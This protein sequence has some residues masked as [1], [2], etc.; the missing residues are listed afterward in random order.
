MKK[1][2]VITVVISFLLVGIF[3]LIGSM[4]PKPMTMGDKKFPTEVTVTE[5]KV[6]PIKVTKILPA[7]IRA[8]ESSQVRPQISGIVI[9]RFFEEGSLVKK[10]QSLYQIDPDPIFVELEQ[11]KIKLKGSKITA[12]T[13]KENY[14]RHL[15]LF[16][17]KAVSKLQLDNA[18]ITMEK[19]KTDYAIAKSEFKLLK[20][21]LNYSKVLAPISGKIGKSY[22]TKGQLVKDMQEQPMAIITSLEK[23]YADI[24]ESSNEIESIQ[25]ALMKNEEVTVEIFLSDDPQNILAHG[26]LKF[27]ES[28]VD[29]STGSVNLRAEFDNKDRK[30]M[31][32]LFVKVKLNL[33]TKNSLTVNQSSVIINPDGTM[34]V[35]IV[36]DKN[37]AVPKTI[38]ISGQSGA[39]WIVNS[40]ISSGDLVVKEGIQKIGPGSSLIPTLTNEEIINTTKNTLTPNPLTKKTFDKKAEI[41]NKIKSSSNLNIS[42]N[43]FI[44]QVVDQNLLSKEDAATNSSIEV[45]KNLNHK[46]ETSEIDNKIYDFIK[47]QLR[48]AKNYEKVNILKEE[49]DPTKVSKKTPQIKDRVKEELE[50]IISNVNKINQPIK[51]EG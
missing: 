28:I 6:K 40:G 30:L 19:A 38:T 49:A 33:G 29:E 21:R 37:K 26:V 11:A 5:I 24:S 25:D 43:I 8:L 47:K 10:G 15:K 22:V 27:S 12:N 4:I 3:H 14:D 23:L 36:N 2:V 42:K 17:I 1:V 20:I 34:M 32:G 48:E 46:P 41:E 18:R 44:D 9:E 7:R 50:Q 35:Y 16:A 51:Q 31:P 13:R 39:D 45:I